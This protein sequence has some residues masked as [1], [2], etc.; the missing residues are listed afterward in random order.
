[1]RA[2]EL[3]VLKH[4]DLSRRAE[5]LYQQLSRSRPYRD[6]FVRDPGGVIV[7]TILTGYRD[8]SS[9]QINHANRLF[10]SLLSNARFM[11]WAEDY[12]EKVYDQAREILQ[13]A[14][15]P[16]ERAALLATTLDKAAIYHD[17][18]E[19][20]LKF[21]DAE[22]MYSLFNINT[23]TI[24][25]L[26]TSE[27][28]AGRMRLANEDGGNVAIVPVFVLFVFVAIMAL[29]AAPY[30]DKSVNA[31]SFG[32]SRQDF[33]AVSGF[34]TDQLTARAQELRDGGVLTSVD[35]ATRGP[36]L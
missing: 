3:L 25:A 35:P 11:R 36:V 17:L 2:E 6:L 30:N 20:M 8:L 10:F 31:E 21:A 26:E 27:F 34:L 19:S 32:L 15:D 4:D 29:L 1:M 9:T 24:A 5:A 7:N 22:L 13:D 16:I 14:A 12:R 23:S 18:A 33:L 28:E